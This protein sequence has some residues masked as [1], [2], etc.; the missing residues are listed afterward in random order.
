MGGRS[1]PAGLPIKAGRTRKGRNE[2]E[3]PANRAG[4]RHAE[5]GLEGSDAHPAR[6]RPP[7]NAAAPRKRGDTQ[8]AQRPR[9]R[10]IVTPRGAKTPQSDSVERKRGRAR[11]RRS[12]GT[13]SGFLLCSSRYLS[14][15]R[16][17]SL[18]NLA[19]L[20]L[21]QSCRGSFLP[22]KHHRTSCQGRQNDN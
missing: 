19:P 2:V 22:R 6:P 12:R 1:E 20:V 3:D 8:A 7:D 15:A 18:K 21:A 13:P 16:R 4:L 10:P 11:P 9:V 5:A 17:C 14:G